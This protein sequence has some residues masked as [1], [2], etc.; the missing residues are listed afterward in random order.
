MSDRYLL[1]GTSYILSPYKFDLLSE[2]RPK[3]THISP[4]KYLEKLHK[5]GN[6]ETLTTPI[7]F[8]KLL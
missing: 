2:R 3:K 6:Q 4:H 5:Q 1:I 8:Y 7:K